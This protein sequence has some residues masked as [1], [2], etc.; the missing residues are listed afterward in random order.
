MSFL[1]QVHLNL[2]SATKRKVACSWDQGQAKL[3]QHDGVLFFASNLVLENEERQN[4][5]LTR[6]IERNRVAS[7]FG[8]KYQMSRLLINLP[9]KAIEEVQTQ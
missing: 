3:P 5:K 2:P 4:Q 6:P 1:K 9:I 7:R 8:S